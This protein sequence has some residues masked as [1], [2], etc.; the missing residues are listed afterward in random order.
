MRFP[1]VMLITALLAAP[2]WAKGHGGGHGVSGGRGA[3]AAHA[4]DSHATI[5]RGATSQ[6]AQRGVA[7]RAASSFVVSPGTNAPHSFANCPALLVDGAFCP[8][9]GVHVGGS[10][11]TMQ[12][13]VVPEERTPQGAPD[14]DLGPWIVF[15]WMGRA[16]SSAVHSLIAL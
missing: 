14:S 4:Q 12:T 10:F 11:V 1:V 8:F 15:L 9:H 7:L 3:T 16:I 5:G 6:N 13:G 2:V